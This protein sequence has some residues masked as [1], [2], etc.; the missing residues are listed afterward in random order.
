MPSSAVLYTLW[1]PVNPEVGSG[2][3][4]LTGPIGSET[5]VTRGQNTLVYKCDVV[6]HG[7]TPIFNVEMALHLKFMEVVDGSANESSGKVREWD[8]PMPEIGV[9][10]D[11][12]FSFYILGF[13]LLTQRGD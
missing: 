6:N 11:G 10:K 4:K 8:V 3:A 13:K 7:N 9:G 1:L 5:K 2:L 12:K